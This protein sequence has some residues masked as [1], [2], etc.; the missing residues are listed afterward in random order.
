[1]MMQVPLEVI[2]AVMELVP[3]PC[4]LIELEARVSE[5][6]PASALLV[7]VESVTVSVK[8]QRTLLAQI[9]SKVIYRRDMRQLTRDESEKTERLARVLA[10]ALHIWGN[11][12][13]ARQYLATPHM[14]LNGQTP[15]DVVLTELGALRVEELL[16]T[17]FYGLPA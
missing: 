8:V 2:A 10:A 16:W 15:L 17:L 4:S 1:M 14:L 7:C 5:G 6:L 11:L 9:S 3:V 13:D 12:S